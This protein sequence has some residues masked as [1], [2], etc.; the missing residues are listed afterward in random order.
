MQVLRTDGGD[1]YK[2]LD[3]FCSATGVSLQ[4][5]E[6][7]NQAR[8]GKAER[9]HRTIMNMVRRMVFA[10]NI[11]LSFRVGAAEY[12]SYLL[13]RSKTKS[14]LGELSPMGF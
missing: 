1:E 3:I 14:N 10:S 4:V 7:Q 13:N 11:P 5:S 2:T 6:A 12:S 9:M 8:N